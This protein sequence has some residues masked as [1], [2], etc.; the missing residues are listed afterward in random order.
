MRREGASVVMSGS[1]L[2]RRTVPRMR[3]AEEAGPS[4]PGPAGPPPGA[5]S[6]LRPA[7]LR[8]RATIAHAGR[9]RGT[10]AILCACVPSGCFLPSRADLPSLARLPLVSR[11]VFIA[12][13][14]H[15]R[16]GQ[17]QW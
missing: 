1:T 5:N 7:G 10:C 11:G 4:G 16:A 6:Q 17:N 2:A 12:G 13:D 15:P 3:A 8:S 9:M 14:Y